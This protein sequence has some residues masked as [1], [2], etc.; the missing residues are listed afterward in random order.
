M[1]ESYLK[2]KW[3][4]QVFIFDKMECLTKLTALK[5]RFNT[6]ANVNNEDLMTPFFSE[7]MLLLGRMLSPRFDPTK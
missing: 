5:M 3:G 1:I 6:E 7:L 4:H 2:T